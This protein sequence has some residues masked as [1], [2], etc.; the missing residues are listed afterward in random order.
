MDEVKLEREMRKLAKV[1]CS[2]FKNW[3]PVAIPASHGELASVRLDG[4]RSFVSESRGF[5]GETLDS[6]PGYYEACRNLGKVAKENGV[7][8]WIDA[9]YGVIYIGLED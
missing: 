6:I 8:W 5:W 3:N 1:I 4:S 2:F 9:P 7:T